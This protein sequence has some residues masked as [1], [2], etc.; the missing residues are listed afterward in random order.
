VAQTDRGSCR[1]P[2]MA[3]PWLRR[4]RIGGKP[5]EKLLSTNVGP[6]RIPSPMRPSLNHKLEAPNLKQT[7]TAGPQAPNEI[8]L[9]GPWK[10]DAPERRSRPSSVWNSFLGVCT[11]LGIC[12]MAQLRP[13]W[14]TLRALHLGKRTLR[15]PGM[16]ERTSRR[17]RLL[18]NTRTVHSWF[19]Y[20]SLP[21]R[22]RERSRCDPGLNP[23]TKAKVST[24]R[25]ID[26]FISP[27]AIESPHVPRLQVPINPIERHWRGGFRGSRR[28]AGR[29]TRPGSV[30]EGI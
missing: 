18:F 11:L 4:I 6:H 29:S 19:P 10:R 22:C 30:P 7:P 23:A 9:R 13:V 2:R 12:G 14:V 20:R 24:A 26:E 3:E 25:G 8:L 5:R 17:N 1:P 21:S 27:T 16:Q 28:S 15:K